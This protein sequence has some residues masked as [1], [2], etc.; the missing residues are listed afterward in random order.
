M[1]KTDL[2]LATQHHEN[3]LVGGVTNDER[4]DSISSEAVGGASVDDLPANY[5]LSYKFI[6]SFIVG[7][8][9]K[10]LEKFIC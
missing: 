9:Y 5:F 1:D 3:A 7:L 6:G 2:D 10:L 4:P 8:G